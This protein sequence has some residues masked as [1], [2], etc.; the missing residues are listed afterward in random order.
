MSRNET[1]TAAAAYST[2]PTDHVSTATTASAERAGVSTGCRVAA[3][4]ATDCDATVV[5]L[6]SDQVLDVAE[7]EAVSQQLE[8]AHG[9]PGVALGA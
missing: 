7:V 6:T 9:G 1:K 2:S 4:T 5:D 8:R 3:T